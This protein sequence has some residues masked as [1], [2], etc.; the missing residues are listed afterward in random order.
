MRTAVPACCGASPHRG[1]LIVW[2]LYANFVDSFLFPRANIEELPTTQ[3]SPMPYQKA[4]DRLPRAIKSQMVKLGR[5][6]RATPGSDECPTREA[7]DHA[8]LMLPSCLVGM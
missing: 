4:S 3:S 7:G 1:N 8:W 2:W 6:S 5:G